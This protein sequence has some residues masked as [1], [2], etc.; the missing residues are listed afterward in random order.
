MKTAQEKGMLKLPKMK[1][2]AC[3]AQERISDLGYLVGIWWLLDVC[4]RLDITAEHPCGQVGGH[5]NG[6]L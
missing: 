3:K 1:S 2:K 6:P 5:G 4:Q